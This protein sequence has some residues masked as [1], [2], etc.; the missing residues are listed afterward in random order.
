MSVIAHSAQCSTPQH[1]CDPCLCPDSFYS[2]PL[3][4]IS[5]SC[6]CHA[7][8]LSSASAKSCFPACF[9]YNNSALCVGCLLVQKFNNQNSEVGAVKHKKT[10]F[11]FGHVPFPSFGTQCHW[12]IITSLS[13]LLATFSSLASVWACAWLPVP[14]PVL[15]STHPCS[16]PCSVLSAPILAPAQ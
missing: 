15:F 10:T 11:V 4:N 1:L 9:L 7:R 16:T 14:T 12:F 8:L 6:H 3:C 2:C 13:H 5:A